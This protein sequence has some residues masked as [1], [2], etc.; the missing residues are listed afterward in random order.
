MFDIKKKVDLSY[1]GEDWKDCYLHFRPF[2]IGEV[3]KLPATLDA[4]TV[5]EANNA[6]NVTV[7]LLEDLFIDGK[8]RVNGETVDVKKEDMKEFPAEVVLKIL[9]DLNAEMDKKKL[10]PLSTSSEDTGEQKPPTS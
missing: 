4:K 7:G 1:L 6:I 3:Q 9:G 10:N 8:A 5:E 2:S